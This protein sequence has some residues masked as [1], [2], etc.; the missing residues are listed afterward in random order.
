MQ[1]SSA[2]CIEVKLTEYI[3]D[4]VTIKQFVSDV[5]TVNL[6]GWHPRPN[7]VGQIAVLPGQLF[8]AWV[9]VDETKFTR[10]QVEAL[11]GKMGTLVFSING[12][13]LHVNI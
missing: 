7:G 4:A 12:D 2:N 10:E 8:R 6:G 1:N 13:A 5:L 9:D 11:R 3:S